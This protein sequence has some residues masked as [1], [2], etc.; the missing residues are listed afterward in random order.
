MEGYLLTRKGKGEILD[1]LGGRCKFTFDDEISKILGVSVV[2]VESDVPTEAVERL[3]A[4]VLGLE[5]IMFAGL[6]HFV[7]FLDMDKYMAKKE[8][9]KFEGS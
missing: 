1:E 2:Y 3:R 9:P 8:K 7:E 5:E 6:K 4:H